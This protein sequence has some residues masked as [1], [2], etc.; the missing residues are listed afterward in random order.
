MQDRSS[1]QCFHIEGAAK[2]VLSQISHTF[3]AF[4]LVRQIA[5]SFVMYVRM[6]AWNDSA[7]TGRMFMKFDIWGFF[8]NL[9]CKFKFH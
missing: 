6:S 2:N 5:E 7:P 9:A 3:P 4:K 1:V 8:E